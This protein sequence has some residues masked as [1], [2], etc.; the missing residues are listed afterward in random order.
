MTVPVH[1]KNEKIFSWTNNSEKIKKTKVD[2]LHVIEDKN[3]RSKK[4]DEHSRNTNECFQEFPVEHYDHSEV[5][6]FSQLDSAFT[7]V[8]K[9]WFQENYQKKNETLSN[10]S[11]IQE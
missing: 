9:C 1:V 2:F 10:Y 6:I 3:M 8:C 5:A 7:Q 4:Q 11:T